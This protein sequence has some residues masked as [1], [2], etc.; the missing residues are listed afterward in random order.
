MHAAYYSRIIT[1]DI[2]SV[3][4]ASKTQFVNE[5][6]KKR[7]CRAAPVQVVWSGNAPLYKNANAEQ[8]CL[9]RTDS[10]LHIKLYV[11]GNSITILPCHT[12]SSL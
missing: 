3:I 10:F 9:K 8:I 4:L 6:S 2:V 12:T 7:H 1:L 5:K 11:K